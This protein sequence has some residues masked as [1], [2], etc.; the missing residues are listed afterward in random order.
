MTIKDKVNII[1]DV[2]DEYLLLVQKGV[3]ASQGVWELPGGERTLGTPLEQSVLQELNKETGIHAKFLNA[4]KPFWIEIGTA[5]GCLELVDCY[6]AETLAGKRDTKVYAVSLEIEAEQLQKLVV[7]GRDVRAVQLFAYHAI[8]EILPDHATFLNDYFGG[9]K[10]YQNPIPT[11]D[12]I[13][14]YEGKYVIIDRKEEP[15]GYALPGGHAKFGKT[16]EQSFREEMEEETGLQVRDVKFVGYYDNP[17]RDNRPGHRMSFVFAAE[18]Y[19]T[20]KAG[21]DAKE[22]FLLEP[23]LLQNVTFAFDHGTIVTDY[24]NSLHQDERLGN[25]FGKATEIKRTHQV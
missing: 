3:N 15:F 16:L 13:I 9:L 18:G 17:L 8:P 1:V 7:P 6:D 20:L 19:G 21:S 10:R 25:Q 2:N 24:L 23:A 4:K 5:Q 22:V 14:M 12:G 11:V